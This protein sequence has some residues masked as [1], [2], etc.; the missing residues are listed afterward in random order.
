MRS[1]GRRERKVEKREKS[2]NRNPRGSANFRERRG[3]L[4]GDDEMELVR[5]VRAHA[6]MLAVDWAE[7][8]ETT[9]RREA[10]AK[11]ER[12]LTGF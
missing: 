1:G 3:Q 11:V 10:R 8:E 5:Q 9:A 4:T 2:V 6:G 7:T 12:I